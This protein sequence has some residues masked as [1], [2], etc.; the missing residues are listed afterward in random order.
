MPLH[1]GEQC[2]GLRG[3]WLLQAEFVN[4]SPAA[5]V[6]SAA[7]SAARLS[8]DCIAENGF[9]LPIQKIE[10]VAMAG[11]S[12]RG[13]LPWLDTC[14]FDAGRMAV[15]ALAHNSSRSRST[16]PGRGVDECAVQGMHR[17][18]PAVAVEQDRLDH[19]LPASRPRR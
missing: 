14:L 9:A 10:A 8:S 17:A 5:A 19:R 1:P 18:L 3:P 12:D 11:A 13:D 15:P 4:G 2:R 16:C 7:S 6:I